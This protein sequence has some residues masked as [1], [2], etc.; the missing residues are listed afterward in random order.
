MNVLVTGAAGFVGSFVCRK[1]VADGHTVTAALEPNTSSPRLD[2]LAGQIRP[3]EIDL[4]R[5]HQSD[6]DRL[7]T[8]IDVAIHCAW[9]A[10]PG[11]YLTSLEN[12]TALSGSLNLM[13]TLWKN[14][15]RKVVGVGTCV[16]YRMDTK[17]LR[18]DSPCEPSILYGAA[19]WSTFLTAQP[20]ARQLGGSLAWARLFYL[21][22]PREAKARLIPDLAI[23]LLQGKR[24]AVT[25]GRQIR[26]YMHIED[27]AS[28]L[29]SIAFS[30]MEGPCNVG[31]G[32]AR[33][34]RDIIETL[35]RISGGGNLV[36]YGA[37]PSNLVDPPYIVADNTKLKQTGWKPKY[38]L[39]TGLAQTIDWWRKELAA[40]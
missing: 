11:L 35:A 38:T 6:L 25:E 15:C 31:S 34:V 14:G 30:E 27:V 3:V 39:D 20:L 37:R 4:F 22:G 40:P 13:A 9:Y 17:P 24:V 16:E 19:K 32:D 23:H 33:S 21:Y 26:D 10:V 29:V 8:G 7:A 18:E 12:I 5:A 2:D 36:D 1:L 28:G